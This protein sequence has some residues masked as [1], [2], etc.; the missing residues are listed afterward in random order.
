MWK[1]VCAVF[2]TWLWLDA[3]SHYSPPRQPYLYGYYLSKR[4]AGDV[5]TEASSLCTAVRKVSV[6]GAVLAAINSWSSSFINPENLSVLVKQRIEKK[7][8][9]ATQR[10]GAAVPLNTLGELRLRSADTLAF[11]RLCGHSWQ[12]ACRRVPGC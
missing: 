11:Q 4:Y 3:V 12:Q 1:Y 7:R 6:K 2:S 5:I 8:R 10:C 9:V